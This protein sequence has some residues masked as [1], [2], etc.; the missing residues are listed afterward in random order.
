MKNFSK[1]LQLAEAAKKARVLDEFFALLLTPV[2]E[3]QVLKRYALIEALIQDKLP[4]RE[5]A[6][7]LEIS[8]AKIT[9][10][11]NALKQID[12]KLAGVLQ[13]FFKK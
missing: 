7:D 13:R 3:K 8:I 1:I 10:G 11:S 5:I 2:E 6:K 4:Q 12:P 9:R